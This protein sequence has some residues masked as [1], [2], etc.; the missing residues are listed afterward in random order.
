MNTV[1]N[2]PEKIV[3][4]LPHVVLQYVK[5]HYPEGNIFD[6][7]LDFN[8]HGELKH[9]DVDVVDAFK[10]YHLRFDTKGHF[11]H[12]EIEVGKIDLEELNPNIIEEKEPSVNDE[13][14]NEF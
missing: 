8:V 1:M 4:T 2:N 10:T 14:V 13:E 5:H 12:E 9:Y 3:H 11:M 7:V 6:M